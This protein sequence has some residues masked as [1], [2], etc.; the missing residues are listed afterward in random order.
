MWFA[1]PTGAAGD[2]AVV[3]ITSTSV[4]VSWKPLGVGKWNGD[5][6]TG[7]YKVEYRQ[8]LDYPVASVQSAPKE[9]VRGT[10]ATT[11]V[12]NDLTRD[13]NYEITVTPYNS[14]G[15]GE[16]SRPVTVYVGE[17]VPTGEPREAAIS[18]ASSTEIQM[19]WKP[20]LQNQQNGD[21]LGYKVSNKHEK[22]TFQKSLEI[23]NLN[24]KVAM[25]VIFC[26]FELEKALK[27][28][29][30]LTLSKKT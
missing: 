18:P 24:L 2:V 26:S 27:S 17:A 15:D 8:V 25:I 9:E 16:T 10:Q 28:N 20:P 11:V 29:S 1:A 13:K 19:S 6:E 12:L 30:F 14:R 7:G 23:L 3:P 5:A 21:L 22:L 4:R